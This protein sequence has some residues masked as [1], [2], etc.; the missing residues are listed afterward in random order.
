MAKGMVLPRRH[1]GHA[2]AEATRIRDRSPPRPTLQPAIFEHHDLVNFALGRHREGNPDDAFWL[3]PPIDD[4]Q[5]FPAPLSQQRL[6]DLQLFA[7]LTARDVCSGR[8]FGLSCA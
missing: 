8:P 7:F 3:I 2:G 5:R 1:S 6:E 4:A